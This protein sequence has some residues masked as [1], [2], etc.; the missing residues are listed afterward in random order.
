MKPEQVT[1][2]HLTEACPL[3]QSPS[4]WLSD[5]WHEDLDL[6]DCSRF[7]HWGQPLALGTLTT[8]IGVGQMNVGGTVEKPEPSCVVGDHVKQCSSVKKFGNS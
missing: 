8:R 2:K 3:P 1:M 5:Q 7:T 6:E 4:W